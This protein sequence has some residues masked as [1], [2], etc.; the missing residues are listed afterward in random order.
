M[1]VPDGAAYRLERAPV[2]GQRRVAGVSFSRAG[3]MERHGRIAVANRVLALYLESVSGVDYHASMEGTD[4]LLKRDRL[5]EVLRGYGRVVV[6]FSG[7]IDSTVVA[8]AA[9]LALGEQ[10]IA[11]TA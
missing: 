9:F 3:S 4:L 1:Q 11:V 2:P 10:A 6:A 7:G 5:L 8:Q